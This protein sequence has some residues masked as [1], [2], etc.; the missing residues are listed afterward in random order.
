M[1]GG[2]LVYTHASFHSGP[3]GDGSQCLGGII[4]AGG[5]DAA[6]VGRG[7]SGC[8]CSTGTGAGGGRVA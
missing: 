3:P 4:I 6:A 5:I 2:P 7:G 8:F 1:P